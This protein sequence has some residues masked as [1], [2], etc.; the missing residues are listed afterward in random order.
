M[1]GTDEHE[2]AAADVARLR[3]HDGQG[4]AHGHGRVDG[5]AAR[6]EDFDP[7][8]RGVV[9]DRDD[10]RV[11]GVGGGQRLLRRDA[12][13]QKRSGKANSGIINR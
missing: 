12:G 3:Q 7:G 4:E 1:R 10:Y 9:V 11:R 6:A 2:A 8:V 13:W 5:V